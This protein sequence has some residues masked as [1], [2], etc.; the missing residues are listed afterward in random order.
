MT[1]QVEVVQRRCYITD[2]L[3]YCVMIWTR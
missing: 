2:T 1:L 3:N